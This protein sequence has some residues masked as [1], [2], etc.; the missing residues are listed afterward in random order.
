MAESFPELNIVL[1]NVD[2]SDG[3]VTAPDRQHC[4]EEILDTVLAENYPNLFVFSQDKINGP[5]HKIL[6]KKLGQDPKSFRCMS[7]AG[8]YHRPDSDVD[9]YDVSY[10]DVATLQQLDSRMGLEP[11]NPFT[12]ARLVACVLTPRGGGRNGKKILLVSWHGPLKSK[13]KGACFRRLVRFSERLRRREGCE[14]R[15]PSCQ[16]CD[17]AIIGGDF[18]MSDRDAQRE[19]VTLKTSDRMDGTV[20][21]NY[22]TTDDRRKGRSQECIDYVVY[23]PKGSVQSTEISVLQREFRREKGNRPFDHPIVLYRF[24]DAFR[25]LAQ[26]F[27]NITLDDEQR[28]SE[29][30]R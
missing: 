19:M 22:T 8:V 9:S 23:W 6:C 20:L 29:S 7:E 30:G 16:C 11:N 28:E 27:G 2:S 4:M 5:K 1:F 26:Q 17:I 3:K 25:D 24:G 15:S 14:H 18:N 12:T 21:G 10:V 13:E